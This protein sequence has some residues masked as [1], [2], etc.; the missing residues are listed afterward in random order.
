MDMKFLVGT[1][2]GLASLLPAQNIFHG[3]GV[4]SAYIVN[5]PAVVDQV[6]RFDL[7]STSAPGGVGAI[8][9]SGGLGPT[10]APFIGPIG[11]DI[12]STFY[13][14]TTIFLDAT[15]DSGFQ[16]PLP[17]GITNASMAPFYANFLTIESAAPTFSVTKTVRV[18]FANALGWEPVGDL[19]SVRQRHTATPLGSNPRDNVTQVLIAGGLTGSIVVPAPMQSAEL[20]DPLTRTVSA[21]PDMSLPRAGHRAVRLQDGRVLVSGGVTTGGVVTDTCDVFD[22]ALQQ[23]I[24]GASM[25]T[26]RVGHTLT[27]LS[28]GRVL[29]TGG[30]SDW[31]NAA[32]HF[33]QV[34]NTSQRSTE[35]FDPSS[36]TWTPGP[37]MLDDRAG[38]T[39]TRL[40]NDKVLLIAGINGGN[41]GNNPLAAGQGGEV[42]TYTDTCELFDPATNTLHTW[43]VA[44][45][46]PFMPQFEG[47][48]GFHAA[49][50]LPNGDVLV[51]G[52]FIAGTQNGEA[53]ATESTFRW[54]FASGGYGTTAA[55][56]REGDLPASVG[57]HTQVRYEGGVLVTG[58]FT[59]DLTV[60]QTVAMNVFHDGM[61]AT[62]RAD[63]GTDAGTGTASPRGGHTC[64]RLYDGTLLIYGGGQWPATLSSGYVYTPTLL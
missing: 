63:L 2:L 19:L 5:T 48:R 34:L 22:P 44:I 26:P 57:M 17:P 49:S 15:G 62:S 42:P 6:L 24:T 61:T 13:F 7:G 18:E 3:N 32:A 54:D 60:L 8:T 51:T 25:N 23:F 31:Q 56:R 27:L 10:T 53:I 12:F 64:T 29:A 45:S 30:F 41:S 16:I 47:G 37:D 50:L 28:D 43:P 4:P 55:W 36:N 21:L 11:L 1:T 14:I 38:H 35:I 9:L 46:G 52:G 58:G 40:L 20:Y 33:I 59:G 39:A